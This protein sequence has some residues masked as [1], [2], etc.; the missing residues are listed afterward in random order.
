MCSRILMCSEIKM[1]YLLTCPPDL[2]DKL[3]STLALPPKYCLYQ[4]ARPFWVIERKPVKSDSDVN[5]VRVWDVCLNQ[6]RQSP[7][8][9]Q[10]KKVKDFI[11]SKTYYYSW[12][13]LY[14]S[15][16]LLVMKL[17]LVAFQTGV[18]QGLEGGQVY[19]RKELE[20]DTKWANWAGGDWFGL[21]LV[22]GKSGS[23]VH[24]WWGSCQTDGSCWS[25]SELSS[26][27]IYQNPMTMKMII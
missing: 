20:F 15:F 12:S 3:V 21:T 14:A 2:S 1:L 22:S 8:N 4:P 26:G 9:I 7:F 23:D 11:F 18:R 24:M 13:S 27:L 5:T 19:F 6:A 17:L 10:I 16:G 25:W